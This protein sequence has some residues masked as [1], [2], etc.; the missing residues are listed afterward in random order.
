M[1]DLSAL[2]DLLGLLPL[3]CMKL[4]FMQQALLALLLLA[5]MAATLGVEVIAFRMAFFSDA[6]GHSAFTGVALGLLLGIDPRLTMPAFG[7]LTGLT[8]MALRRGSPLS[9]DTVIGIVF[10][11]SIAFGLA[12]VGRF[13]G[14]A[15]SMQQFLYGDILTISDK[16][17]LFLALLLAVLIIFQT[18]GYNRLLAVALHPAMARAHGVRVAFWQYCFVSLLALVV[19][20]SVWAVGILLVTALLIVPAAAARNFARTAGGM[21]WWAALIGLVS[22]FAGLTLS[23]WEHSSAPCGA[24]II[25]VACAVFALS[26]AYARLRTP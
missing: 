14:L 10:S 12:V 18:F 15:R 25:L 7:V 23:A 4:R 21:L 1:P 17:I 22:A 24:M 5:P 3:E 2:Y 6:I 26:H 20:F 16:E 11:G 8:I 19:T 13:N 9:A